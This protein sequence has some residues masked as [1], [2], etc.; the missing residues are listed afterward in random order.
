MDPSIAPLSTALGVLGMVGGMNGWVRQT[1][2]VSVEEAE[3]IYVDMV[4]RAVTPLP[5]LAGRQSVSH[6]IQ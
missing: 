2:R 5:V 6:V 4:A 1:A 3:T